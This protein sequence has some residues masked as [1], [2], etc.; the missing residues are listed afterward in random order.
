MG[1]ILAQLWNDPDYFRK[2]VTL[3]IGGAAV[4]LPVLP[5]G[6]L[7]SF[8]YW[9]SKLLLPIAITLGA[10]GRS[11]GLTVDEATRLRALLAAPKV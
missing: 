5:L 4:I 1:K 2:V 3:L 9:T 11:S 8:G 7:G 6:E 10:T